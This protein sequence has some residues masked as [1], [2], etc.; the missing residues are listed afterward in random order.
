MQEEHAKARA[1][2]FEAERGLI[3]DETEPLVREP[4]ALKTE[5]ASLRQELKL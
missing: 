4:K 3:H 2:E 5:I 1:D